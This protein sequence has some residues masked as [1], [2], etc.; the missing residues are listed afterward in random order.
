MC[1]VGSWT[2][3]EAEHLHRETVRN[4]RGLVVFPAGDVVTVLNAPL[5]EDEYGTPDVLR[6]WTA[7]TETDVAG[8][9]VAPRSSAEPQEPGRSALSVGLTVYMPPGVPVDASSR[10]LIAGTLYE[11]EGEPAVWK[12]PYVAGPVGGVEVAVSRVAG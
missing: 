2:A 11:V 1:S 7:A 5:I 9:A 6:D 4:G 10:L 8:C 3:L 12:S